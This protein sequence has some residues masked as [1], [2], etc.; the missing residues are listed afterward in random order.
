MCIEFLSD[1]SGE[2][3]MGQVARA[4][5]EYFK[6]GE[7]TSDELKE[8]LSEK[9]KLGHILK[10]VDDDCNYKLIKQTDGFRILMSKMN[11]NSGMLYDIFITDTDYKYKTLYHSNKE[12]YDDIVYNEYKE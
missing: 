2:D 7:P 8:F 11:C 10:N 9:Y 12:N 4:I 6:L 3:I 5:Y 1:K